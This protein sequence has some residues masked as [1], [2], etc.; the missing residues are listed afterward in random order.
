MNKQ[1]I[2]L[3]IM[4]NIKIILI[5]FVIFFLFSITIYSMY[6]IC[7]RKIS[8]LNTLNNGIKFFRFLLKFKYPK[9]KRYRLD[10]IK[11]L[12]AK[13]F[14]PVFQLNMFWTTTTHINLENVEYKSEKG[15]IE[16]KKM[17]LTKDQ[18]EIYYNIIS[19]K[20]NFDIVKDKN[21]NSFI[22]NNIKY[23]CDIDTIQKKISV[24]CSG[25]YI[26]NDSKIIFE[27]KIKYNKDIFRIEINTS[28][29]FNYGDQYDINDL[30]D[31][32]GF[33]C[34]LCFLI[35]CL[36]TLFICICINRKIL[37]SIMLINFL[38]FRSLSGVIR[39]IFDIFSEMKNSQ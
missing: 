2:I 18:I 17:I 23:K 1:E 31:I 35:C 12:I 9:L 30:I 24:N 13:V 8:L 25:Y 37:F 5:S 39:R 21:K 34:Q 14:V 33:L 22:I 10:S 28:D 3:L 11:Q 15:T 16:L 20:H 38:V 27:S 7:I 36:I 26:F 29:F 32:C 4:L 19:E 6:N